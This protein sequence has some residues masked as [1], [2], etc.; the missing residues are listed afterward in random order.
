MHTSFRLPTTAAV[1]PLFVLVLALATPETR[2][3]EAMR[4][5]IHEALD[6]NVKLIEIQDLPIRDAL[7]RLQQ[8]TGLRFE[9]DKPVLDL[10]PYG[11]RTKISIVIRD[12]SVRRAMTQIAAGLGLRLEPAD[13]RVH[14]VAAPVLARL[15]RRL[16]IEEVRLLERL[17]RDTWAAVRGDDA[18]SVEL[19]FPPDEHAEQ[20]FEKTM[21]QVRQLE[22]ATETL[23]WVWRPDGMRIVLEPR[24]NEILRRLDE[25]LDTT[26]Q[27][28]ALDKLLVDLGSQ[29]GITIF[30]EPGAL[31]AVDARD[32]VVDLIQRG[33][34]FRQTL[35]RICGNT[36]LRYDITDEGVVILP[37]LDAES[38]P[39]KSTIEQWVRIELEI[40]PG[41]KMDVFLRKDELPPDIQRECA[42]KLYEIFNG[43]GGRGS[44]E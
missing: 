41:I 17:A 1:A 40:R 36:G 44:Q 11:E 24:V 35:E 15:G 16:T 28:V 31:K 10:M 5:L 14:L 7:S 4:D 43:S 39:T 34:S 27:R 32:R 33:I 29:I 42:D 12:M 38:G 8:E 21:E 9:L 19:R 25:P 23:G 30:F 20:V 2:G 37:P 18:I 22:A 6:Q 26:C 13:D 3:Q